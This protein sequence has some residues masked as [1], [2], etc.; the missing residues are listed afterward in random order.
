[1]GTQQSSRS[2]ARL[3]QAS[4]KQTNTELDFIFKRPIFWRPSYIAQSA[5]LEHIPFAF[6][7]IDTLQPQGKFMNMPVF[8]GFVV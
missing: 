4:E 5:W 3:K 2:Q 6:W 7:L 8:T 1:M